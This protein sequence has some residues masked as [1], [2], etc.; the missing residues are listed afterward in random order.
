MTSFKWRT[1]IQTLSL[2]LMIAVLFGLGSS[3]VAIPL[4]QEGG[5]FSDTTVEGTDDLPD[6]PKIVRTRF[7]EPNFEMLGGVGDAH[8]A[9]NFRDSTLCSTQTYSISGYVRNSSNVGIGY[10]DVDFDG[11]RPAVTTD[12]SG[13][14]SQ[15]GFADDNYIV[16]FGEPGYFFSPVE[17]LV[18]VNGAN[19]THDATAYPIIP[20]SLP[21]S[22][23][24]E[25]GDLGTAWAVETDYDGRVR[26]DTF[27]PHGGSYS[28]LLDNAV[29]DGFFSYASAILALNL[30]GLSEVE[31][32]FWWQDFDDDDD[33][34]DGVFISD[35]FGATWYQALSF[36]GGPI[37]TYTHS[38]I[39]LDAAA[40]NAGMSL[41]D[42]FLLKFQF[43]DNFQ[44]DSDGYGIDDLELRAVGPVVYD[45]LVADDDNSGSSSGN[46]NDVIDCGES[47]EL[48]VNL[49]NEGTETITGI[50]ATIS[51]SDPYITF[52]DN[53]ASSYADLVGLETG[54][55]SDDFDFDVDPNTPHTH[56]IS[57]DVD[58]TASNGGPWSDTFDVRVSCITDRVYLPQIVK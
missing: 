43:Y 7:V 9:D 11:A 26:V 3:V 48:W 45:G 50:N 39:D 38:T 10:V 51:S 41:N 22:D 13:Y 52:T 27:A 6:D 49:Y 17:D 16:S 56:Q 18:T 54:W 31:V 44:I 23:G 29:N 42:H 21:F 40:S 47:I 34:Y 28:L 8:A 58:I 14:Y 57:F 5:L 19:A 33:G 20:A 25:S 1:I 2:A 24:F 30:D 4:D 12:N 36:S 37:Y 46:D 55:N 32:S 53:V 35:D 15:S